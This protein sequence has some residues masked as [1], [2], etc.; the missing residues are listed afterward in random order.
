MQQ[1]EAPPTH[2]A[3]VALLTGGGDRPYA[4]GL[5]MSLA[6]RGIRLDFIGS[7][8]LESEELRRRPEVR[9]L[10]LRGDMRPEVPRL[11]KVLRVARYYAR[12]IAY[13]A[14]A[15]PKVFHILWNNK[16]EAFDRTLLLLYYRLLG[17]R[18]VQTVH[19]VNIRKR[20]GRDTA[21]NRFT[22][23]VQYRLADHLFV[24]TQQMRRELQHDFGV[25][26][27]KISVIPFGVNDTVPNTS[28]D[29]AEARRRCGLLASDQVVL[30]YG[31]IAPYKG[32]A[33]LVEAFALVV[34][35]L[36]NCRL[37]V[38]GRPKGSEAYW[39]AI[40]QRIEALGVRPRVVQRIEYIPDD[41]T[42]VYFKAADVLCLP[43]THVF[44]SGVLFLG[45]NFG[46]PVIASDVG[47]L[48]EDVVEGKTGL[49]CKPG[50]ADDLARAL[51]CF[52]ADRPPKHRFMSR[53]EIVA[54][55]HERYSWST[56][57]ATT[58]GVY[59]ALL[60][61]AAADPRATADRTAG[62]R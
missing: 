18:I 52:F 27:A 12:L 53:A 40:E 14:T 34:E 37:V 9:V 19:N 6:A 50:D 55:A 24:H 33:V 35:S 15:T 11:Q 25:P 39:A 23:Q 46:I 26:D 62:H 31:N 17:K 5:A 58:G 10:N 54:L 51:L 4:L 60:A 43:Y 47:S 21:W 1:A 2:R 32:V 36:P 41:E 16:F 44:Q 3:E 45:Y 42:E 56:V 48:R 22:L 20:D 61:P 8:F 29:L 49:V 57:A 38:A 28:M 30:F 7:D 59:S 13:A